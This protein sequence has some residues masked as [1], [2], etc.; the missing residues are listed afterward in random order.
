MILTKQFTF[1]FRLEQKKPV[2]LMIDPCMKQKKEN[3]KRLFK[4]LGF[5]TLKEG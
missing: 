4:I 2:T 3:K 1:L 5:F